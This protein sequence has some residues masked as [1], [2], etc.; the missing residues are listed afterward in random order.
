MA[1]FCGPLVGDFVGSNGHINLHAWSHVLTQNLRHFTHRLIT[2]VG[3]MS[4]AHS[5]VLAML[6]LKYAI[7]GN[8]NVLAN[9]LIIWAH[10]TN[11]IFLG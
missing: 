2:F 10:K 3:L 4:N 6:G 7:T 11:A 9:A 8:E 1:G 5:D